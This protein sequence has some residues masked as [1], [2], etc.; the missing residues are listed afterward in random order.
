MTS[1]P[2]LRWTLVIISHPTVFLNFKAVSNGSL[3]SCFKGGVND[4]FLSAINL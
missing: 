2:F 4:E 1:D 3:T